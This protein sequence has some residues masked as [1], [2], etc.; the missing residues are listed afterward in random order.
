[1]CG[2]PMPDMSWKRE[3]TLAVTADSH[4]GPLSGGHLIAASVISIE[5]AVCNRFHKLLISAQR[6]KVV[7]HP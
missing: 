1:M 4:V 5:V 6:T 3:G 2:R 7:S